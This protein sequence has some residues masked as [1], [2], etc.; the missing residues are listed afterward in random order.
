[1]SGWRRWAPA[2]RGRE[3]GGFEDRRIG[4][5]GGEGVGREGAVEKGWCV[6]ASR[7]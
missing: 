7:P 3:G 4:V 5:W 6:C 1:M 2:M